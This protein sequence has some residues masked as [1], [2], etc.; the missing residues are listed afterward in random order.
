MT[1]SQ[2]WQMNATDAVKAL[3]EKKIQPSE[4]IES[5]IGRIEEVDNKVNA[6]PIRCFERAFEQAKL[7]NALG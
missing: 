5:T 1:S 2:L 4:L 3:K 7:F 6:L